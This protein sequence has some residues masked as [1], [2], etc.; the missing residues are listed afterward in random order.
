M[1]NYAAPR[2]WTTGDVPT[3]AQLNQDLRDNVAELAHPG[4]AHVTMSATQSC[5]HSASEV[6]NALS[7]DTLLYTKNTTAAVNTLTVGE[8]GIWEVSAQCRFPATASASASSVR[9]IK[10]Y[11]NGSPTSARDVRLNVQNVDT[12]CSI[13]A[14]RVSLSAGGTLALLFWQNSGGALTVQADTWLGATLVSRA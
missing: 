7:L 1:A 2:T 8:A 6:Y 14:F 11:A 4:I 5:G 3:A 12:I 13:S 10:L 9:A